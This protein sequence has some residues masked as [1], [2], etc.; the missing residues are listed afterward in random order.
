[1]LRAQL[2]AAI[3]NASKLERKLIRA[4]H[5]AQ[6]AQEENQELQAKLW[7]Q[8]STDVALS[9]LQDRQAALQNAI[10]EHL[11]T[12][13]RLA[14]EVTSLNAT[15]AEREAVLAERESMLVDAECRQ[16]Q[17]DENYAR[18]VAR[19][20]AWE[21]DQSMLADAQ[22]QARQAEADRDA[23]L[24]KVNQLQQELNGANGQLQLVSER[25]HA[26]HEAMALRDAQVTE[27]HGELRR[28]Q[29]EH[30]ITQDALQQAE[31]AAGDMSAELARAVA[32][33]EEARTMLR[34]R[35]S[36][37]ASLQD[38]ITQAQLQREKY[39]AALLLATDNLESLREQIND[40]EAG[41]MLL[42]A[43][44]DNKT[45]TLALAN[46]DLAQL[47]SREYELTV[48]LERSGREHQTSLETMLIH[49]SKVEADLAAS[50]AALQASQKQAGE[51]TEEI[52]A[53]AMARATLETHLQARTSVLATSEAVIASMR[54]Q[55]QER[56]Q[57]LAD[58]RIVMSE[59][60]RELESARAEV[61]YLTTG[62]DS[63]NATANE[64]YAEVNELL[65]ALRATQSAHD[66][67]LA[68][69]ARLSAEIEALRDDLAIALRH[70]NE[71]AGEKAELHAEIASI[72]QNASEQQIALDE[73]TDAKT[74]NAATIEAQ[75]GE[76]IRLS[77]AID[78]AEGVL[79]LERAR[80]DDLVMALEAAGENSSRLQTELNDSRH[81]LELA[82]AALSEL[83]QAQAA[84]L[85]EHEA[86]CLTRDA[87]E[88]QIRNQMERLV[89]VSDEAAALQ[90]QLQERESALQAA[91]AALAEAQ[92]A[93][94]DKPEPGTIESRLIDATLTLQR[95]EKD[96]AAIQAEKDAIE[97]EYTREQM[98][99]QIRIHEKDVA[100][101]NCGAR[102]EALE[103]EIALLK[104][105]QDR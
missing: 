74:S 43:E 85:R 52:S 30:A 40:L 28:L 87:L 95:L 65:S 8:Q 104:A 50:E 2:N 55:L 16:K 21:K 99:G 15:L 42:E 90:K 46:D 20:N 23:A 54:D 86:V 71:L 57:Q 83:R 77:T 5:D 89:A 12:R 13:E 76:I 103:L 96:F 101:S 11:K 56:D 22:M 25:L 9:R 49:M 59:R 47:S 92:Q 24:L 18:L 69:V 37:A 45:Q 33:T 60:G 44:L 61:A 98:A 82:Q 97:D 91:Q 75:A 53:L 88:T 38:Q 102:V 3:N 4:S 67:A 73:L 41:R 58:M 17:L 29:Q 39:E 19:E 10:A 31:D 63:L 68:Q 27:L 7:A 48:A 35:D 64:K 32:A 78:H 6:S 51:L 80:V 94:F 34:L 100:L 93:H 1:M 26:L 36:A 79:K 14:S 105:G 66:A 81:H 62:L 72:L 84:L 70:N